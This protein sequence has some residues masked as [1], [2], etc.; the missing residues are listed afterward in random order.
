MAIQTQHAHDVDSGWALVIL[1]AT[2]F[3][4]LAWHGLVK[5]LSVLLPTFQDQFETH[6]WV[7]GVMDTTIFTVRDFAS[8][9]R[10]TLCQWCRQGYA[11]LEFENYSP[12]CLPGHWPVCEIMFDCLWGS[13]QNNFDII[14]LQKP[15]NKC[16]CLVYPVPKITMLMLWNV[17]N[18]IALYWALMNASNSKLF[19]V[20]TSHYSELLSPMHHWL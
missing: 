15:Q 6:T 19:L 12:P 20:I 16:T 17:M 14:R 2:S 9:Y 4:N 7:I 3:M 13:I 8:K 10:S 5:A 1:A 18:S 11:M